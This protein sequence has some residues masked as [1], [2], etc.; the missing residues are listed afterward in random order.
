MVFIASFAILFTYSNWVYDKYQTFSTHFP[1]L[2]A[3]EDKVKSQHNNIYLF[4][5]K[6]KEREK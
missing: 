3:M 6:K 1:L 4:L 5:E 2:E